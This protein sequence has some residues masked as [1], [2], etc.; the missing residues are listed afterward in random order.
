MRDL[1]GHVGAWAPR[2]EQVAVAAF[3]KNEAAVE[4]FR[5]QMDARVRERLQTLHDGFADLRTAGYPVECVDP[6]GAIYLSLRI[7][8]VGRTFE[9]ARIDGNETI[10]KLVLEHAGLA[11]VPFQAFGLEEETGWFRLSVGAVSMEE[12][13]EMFPRVRALLDRIS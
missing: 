1:I 7:D 5:R 3:L 10:R 6:Q 8:V 4:A 11:I 12:I 9:G 2:P 13:A